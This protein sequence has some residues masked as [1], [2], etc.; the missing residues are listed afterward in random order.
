[1]SNKKLEIFLHGFHLGTLSYDRKNDLY[2]YN[3]DLKEEEKFKAKFHYELE[4]YD[5]WG[6]KNL[7]SKQIPAVF[8]MDVA[9]IKIRSDILKGLKLPEKPVAFDYL[10]ELG[11]F[12]QD[13][14]FMTY[15]SIEN[16]KNWEIFS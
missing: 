1:M 2:T 3:S 6:S 13:D 9:N 10:Y 4:D 7:Q 14:K 5:L 15:K 12:K 11:K 16:Q 8:G